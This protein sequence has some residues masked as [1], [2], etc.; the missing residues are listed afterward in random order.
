[1]IA[2]PI[3]TVVAIYFGL[4]IALTT[5]TPVVAVVGESMHP[6]LK[7]GD[8]VVVQGEPS[9]NIQVGDVIVFD[10]PQGFRTIHRVTQIQ[11]LNGTIQFRTKGDAVDQED[12]D[13]TS[14]RSV[15]G[16]VV[17]QIPYFGYFILNPVMPI[18]IVII[19]AVIILIWPERK[20]R[21]HRHKR[22]HR[23]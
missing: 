17:Y 3:L 11:T 23:G 15:H 12:R 6:A 1:M 8:L 19:I 9:S 14:E 21:F 13:W 20:G 22:A 10:S 7:H 2:L 4:G 16:R 18:T 5:K